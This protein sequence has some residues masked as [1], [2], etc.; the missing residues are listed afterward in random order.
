MGCPGSDTAAD[1]PVGVIFRDGK[2]EVFAAWRSVFLE[3]V[4]DGSCS[5]FLSSDSC[6]SWPLLVICGCC[7]ALPF[8]EDYTRFKSSL[9]VQQWLLTF[10]LHGV[11]YVVSTSKNERL[12]RRM[13]DFLEERK[14]N[15]LTKCDHS[16]LGLTLFFQIR[17]NRDVS[18][19]CSQ[20]DE[21]RLGVRSERLE[22]SVMKWLESN[23]PP[24][25]VTK[26]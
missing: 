16:C 21:N 4:L 23:L 8:L 20:F 25:L 6:A 26:Y 1:C 19:S 5:T 10:S 18:S 24:I 12:L 3:E 22:I 7:S 11:Q 15:V 13:K 14:S 9:W 17:F 2:E